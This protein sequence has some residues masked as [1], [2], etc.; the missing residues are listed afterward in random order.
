METG[1]DPASFGRGGG[2]LPNRAA[3]AESGGL[4]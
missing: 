4:C 3:T 2:P 1:A